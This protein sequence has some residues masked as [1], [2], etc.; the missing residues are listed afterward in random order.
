MVLKVFPVCVNGW[1]MPVLH[2]GPRAPWVLRRWHGIMKVIIPREI[3]WGRRT[4]YDCSLYHTRLRRQL[5]HS[6]FFILA[7][8]SFLQ[9]YSYNGSILMNSGIWLPLA[10]SGILLLS[11]HVMSSGTGVKDGVNHQV[12]TGNWTTASMRATSVLNCSA[13]SPATI[14]VTF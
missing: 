2:G 8:L 1:S 11:Y 3:M 6:A 5:R 14:H 9:C 10:P 7:S 13:I 12:S 4:L